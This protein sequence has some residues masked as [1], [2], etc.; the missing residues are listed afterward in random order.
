MSSRLLVVSIIA[1]HVAIGQTRVLPDI[2]IARNAYETGAGTVRPSD[3]PM[4]TGFRVQTNSLASTFT[5]TTTN[6]T[7]AGS[8]RKAITD[9]NASPGLDYITFN[10]GP[11]GSPITILPKS[12]LPIITSPVVIDGTTEPGYS[13][14]PLVEIRGDNIF[15]ATSGLV[16]WSTAAGSTIRGIGVSFFPGNGM[17]IYANSTVVE[18]CWI[19]FGINNWEL[20]NSYHGI[21]IEDASS[22]RIG[23]S[24]GLTRNVISCNGRFGILVFGQANINVIQGNYIG[25]NPSGTLAPGNRW[26]GIRLNFSSAEGAGASNTLVGGSTP[27]AR[28]I[29]SGNDSAGVG[30]YG[31]PVTN[32]RII[33]NYIG[34]NPAG[35]QAMPNSIGVWFQNFSGQI[36]GTSIHNIIG[37]ATIAERN[38]ISGNRMYG[39]GFV[40]GPS[41]GTDNMIVG[42]VVG[43]DATGLVPL[44]NGADGI[45][46]RL[47]YGGVIS[48]TQIGGTTSDSANIISANHGAGVS[49]TGSGVTRIRIVGNSIHG[50]DGL[51][52]D[53]GGDGPTANDSLDSD[54]GPNNLQN[55]P[56][57]DSITVLSGLTSFHSTLSSAASQTYTVNF[58][59]NNPVA[60]PRVPQGEIVLGS[61]VVTTD[62]TGVV[63]F[64][65]TTN[66]V[67]PGQE[68]T[69]TATDGN[70]NTSEFSPIVQ[71]IKVLRPTAGQLFIAGKKDSIQWIRRSNL[72][73][74][75]IFLDTNGVTLPTPIAV[76]QP[77]SSLKYVWDVPPDL[78][79]RKCRVT[80]RSSSSP[81]IKDTS[82]LFK[83]KGFVLTRIGANDD[84]ERYS[85]DKHGWVMANGDGGTMWPP[86]WYNQFDYRS[87][88]DPNTGE[89]YDLWFMTS[90]PDSF[91]D[92]PLWVRTFGFSDCYSVRQ[93]DGR[94]FSRYDA[95][96]AWDLYSGKRGGSCYGFAATSLLAFFYPTELQ[97]VYDVPSPPRTPFTSLYAFG[98]T[99]LDST[100]AIIN[101][102]FN[103]QWGKE[104]MAY[105][106]SIIRTSTSLSVLNTLKGIFLSDALPG[107]QISVTWSG[108]P[109]GGHALVPYKLV[110]NQR[111]SE[112]W[113]IYVYDCNHPGDTTYFILVDTV[114]NTWQYSNLASIGTPA[115]IYF[116]PPPIDFLFSPTGNW[117][118][119]A[120][121]SRPSKRNVA[122]DISLMV[123][124]PGH[125]QIRN[126]QGQ[127]V[128][129]ADSLSLGI[130]DA[131]PIIPLVG[132]PQKPIGYLL[133]TDTYE[134]TLTGGASPDRSSAVFADSRILSY[135][136]TDADSTQTDFVR[137]GE[138]ILAKNPDTQ[139]RE[140]RL[141]TIL[142]TSVEDRKGV[143]VSGVGL[144]GHDSLALTPLPTDDVQLRNYGKQS[145]YDLRLILDSKTNRQFFEHTGIHLDSLSTHRVVPQWTDL[146]GTGV[147]IY[148]DRG[149]D[150]TVDDSLIVQNETSGADI[151][152]TLE[153]PREYRL[154]QNYP[155]PFNPVTRITYSVPSAGHVSLRVYDI[156]GREVA[157]LVN[158]EKQPGSYTVTFNGQGL[159][160]GVYFYR[161]N[162][163][164][165]VSTK[166]MILTK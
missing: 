29:I 53:L 72:T 42:N 47:P 156:L 144:S 109:G 110:Q 27:G 46:F 113:R 102:L 137:F 134:V 164:G 107:Q 157:T 116:E 146:G 114:L 112:L 120:L 131:L 35:T 61:Q 90:A 106:R 130:P 55:Y 5:V 67:A 33:G 136:R 6:D 165:Y 140:L 50:N 16:V 85:P 56:I 95:F 43:L 57:I 81:A 121:A 26:D 52:I 87:G 111:Y 139:P 101:R 38:V 14:S 73:S 143:E 94:K 125:V 64:V 126:P 70:G 163:Q 4:G 155:N 98:T 100:R 82:A 93:A 80:V 91:P 69:V 129:Y 45:S 77:S 19:G 128:Q 145:T 28:N 54:T 49:L 7:G 99:D 132:G 39:I 115:A 148:I 159:A 37:G 34:T 108:S 2:P 17:E 103:Y 18:G 119:S 3:V 63:R 24:T 59:A 75:D 127:E 71:P 79:S 154:E 162:A 161:F 10:V 104:R 66:L 138:G 97:S 1:T 141:R 30:L 9:A 151:H 117:T 23:D 40:G 142:G 96:N 135:H 147:K 68:L 166:K 25:L 31:A 86:A 13:G 32:N 62:P 118:S 76:N 74:V 150:G 158:E 48:R 51:G 124:T 15:V 8:L 123:K 105:W 149:N 84:Y 122:S 60:P 160:S 58:Y 88:I 11:P 36:T 78:L 152:G 41:G 83:I 65:L 20:G 12:A 92:W 44:G 21:L 133:P 153:T 89:R 22:C